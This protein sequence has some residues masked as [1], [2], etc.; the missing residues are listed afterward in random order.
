[1]PIY[2]LCDQYHGQVA[3]ASV[4]QLHKCYADQQHLI[5]V[6]LIG[7]QKQLL[8]SSAHLFLIFQHLL[9]SPIDQSLVM[10]EEWIT[11]A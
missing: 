5:A 1:M 6:E 10:I 2:H 9:P 8:V 7:S 3:W 4:Q 11:P